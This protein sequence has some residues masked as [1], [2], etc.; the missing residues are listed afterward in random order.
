MTRVLVV[1][2]YIDEPASLGV[3]PYS[4][5]QIRAVLGAALDAGADV[6]LLSIDQVRKGARVEGDA[7]VVMAGCAVPGRYLRGMP[8]SSKEISLIASSFPGERLLGGP[9]VL[10]DERYPGLF[11]HV[12]KKDAAASVYDLLTKGESKDRWRSLMEWN[13]W[14]L[15]GAIGATMHPD[16]PQPLIAEIETYRGCVRYA[17][18]GCSFCVE[19][20]KG[21]PVHRLPQDIIAEVAELHRLGVRNF[22]LGAQTCFVSYMAEEGRSETPRPNPE[23]VEELLEGIDRLG[24]DVLHLDNANPAV[25]SAHPDESR[26]IL[27]SVVRHCT[28]GNILALGMESADPAVVAANNLNATPEQ[29]LDAV[30]LINLAGRERGPTGLPELL[31]GL[32][33][34]IGLDGESARTPQLN[35]DFLRKVRSED[36]WLRRINVRQVSGIRRKFRSGIS[37]SQFLRFKNVVREEIDG[38][39]LRDMIPIGT[40][41]TRVFTEL[42]EGNRT[43]GRQIGTYPI[44]VGFNYPL[45]LGKFLDCMVVDWGYRS[46][47]AVEHPLDINHCPLAAMESLPRVGKKRA[48]RILRGRPYRDLDALSSS[49]DDGMVADGIARFV[50]FG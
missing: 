24:V 18:G 21:K 28:S 35:L 6:S 12:A 22:R 7:L 26:L 46:I 50:A 31:P 32:N 41:L 38:P 49:L 19:P 23:A 2:G 42:R 25:I 9:A 30:K 15:K 34:I 39:M 16:F 14:L 11:E 43:Y 3:P 45:E 20:L 10:E 36:L 27:E 13:R 8:A 37:H 47:T 33:F 4:S 29:V 48:V 1:D 40:K 5:P 44:L 17:S